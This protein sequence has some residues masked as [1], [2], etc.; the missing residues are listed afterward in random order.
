MTIAI[1]SSKMPVNIISSQYH[2][3]LHFDIIRRSFQIAG[4][5]YDLDT[6]Y[7]SKAE[8]VDLL[9]ALR[10]AGIKSVG[11]VVST[12]CMMSDIYLLRLGIRA[13]QTLAA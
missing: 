10:E 12:S 5:L 8:L 6:P 3:Q 13:L 4:R 11:D 9:K 1:A 7:G 2:Q